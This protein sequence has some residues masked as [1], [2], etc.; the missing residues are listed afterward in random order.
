M[1]LR[2]QALQIMRD[3]TRSYGFAHTFEWIVDQILDLGLV[4][5]DP[6]QALPETLIDELEYGE[7]TCSDFRWGVKAA[8]DDI[9]KDNFR[10]VKPKEVKDG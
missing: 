7:A 3:D 2:E 4:E 5:L 10:R 6:N 9:W 1:T 8:Q